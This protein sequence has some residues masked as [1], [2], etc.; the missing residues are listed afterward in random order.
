[1][2]KLVRHVYSEKTV[3]EVFEPTQRDFLDEYADAISD[4]MLAEDFR[5]LVRKSWWVFTVRCRYYFAFSRAV[6]KQ[7]LVAFYFRKVYQLAAG[8]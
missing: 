8:K 4:Y 2:I 1:M 5:T 3:E 6:I 7:N